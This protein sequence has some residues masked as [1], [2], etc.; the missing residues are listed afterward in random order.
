MYPCIEAIE[1]LDGRAQRLE[2]H[3]RRV[4]A[5]F[6]CLFPTVQPFDI[7]AELERFRSGEKLYIETAMHQNNSFF[8]QVGRYKL[9]LMFDDQLR[10]VECIEY[11]QR[12]VETLKLVEV[13]YA[14][15][16]Y[17]S[18]SRQPIDAA[19]A[20]RGNCDDVLLVR[21]GLLTD[22]SYANIALYDG[23]T[24][25]S[26]RIPLLYGTRRAYLIDHQLIVTDD[27]RVEDLPRFQRIRLFNALIGFGELEL[28][29]DKIVT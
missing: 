20:Q 3:Q 12:R 14:T 27:I 5:A 6:R 8:P 7:A 17:K 23:H 21:D 26:P 15:T 22:S 16:S 10:N 18:S 11:H 29:V 19:F 1:W 9:R 25:I 24:W 28:P 13:H 2:Y 4:E